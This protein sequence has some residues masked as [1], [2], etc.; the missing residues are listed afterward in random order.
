MLLSMREMPT[1]ETKRLLL[2]TLV[3]ADI[4]ALTQ[5]RNDWQN[6]KFMSPSTGWPP[7][8]NIGEIVFNFWDKKT[9]TSSTHIWAITEKSAPNLC[10]GYIYLTLNDQNN[11]Q[12]GFCIDSNHHGKGFGKEVTALVIHHAFSTLKQSELFIR[13][14]SVNQASH[15]LQSGNGAK[16]MHTE[17]ADYTIGTLLRECWHLTSES[18]YTAKPEFL[19]T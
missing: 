14:A 11:D 6:M 2:R 9:E 10:I 17:Q 3:P 5:I 15:K 4:H 7:P 13:N 19:T 8:E 1:L 16:I 18:F 12:L